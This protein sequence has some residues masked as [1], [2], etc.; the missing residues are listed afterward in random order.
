MLQAAQ[1][2]PSIAFGL[3]DKVV[4]SI[5]ANIAPVIDSSFGSVSR[6]MPE[7][8]SASE[9]APKMSE[10]RRRWIDDYSASVEFLDSILEASVSAMC[11]EN[12]IGVN[13]EIRLC[14]KKRGD[15][16]WGECEDFQLF[17]EKLAELER[18][19][20]REA[21]LLIKIYF[22]EIDSMIGDK[23]RGY[24]QTCWSGKDDEFADAFDFV[25]VI[26][27]DSD[28]NNLLTFVAVL[29]EI[30]GAVAGLKNA[31]KITNS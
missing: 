19:S 18:Q 13:D 8:M 6:W 20:A 1:L 22:G 5:D 11:T 23:G 17:V 3:F 2:I 14:L 24:M 16:T 21:K 9:A 27:K 30:V 28:H 26:V 31:A 15:A 29:E 7:S 12:T 10:N 4:K 25:S